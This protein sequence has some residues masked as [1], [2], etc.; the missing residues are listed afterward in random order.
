M[1]AFH[2]AEQRNDVEMIYC[3]RYPDGREERRIMA[4]TLRYF[5]RYEV[6][7]LLARS[8]FRIAALYGNFDR[9]PLSDKSPDM[10][11]VAQTHRAGLMACGRSMLRPY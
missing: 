5:F 1:T 7:R 4:W 2:R 10:I 6:E 9:S 3:V 8:G 11:F